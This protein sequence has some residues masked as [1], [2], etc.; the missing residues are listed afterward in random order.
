MTITY[1][2][3]KINYISKNNGQNAILFLH[4]WGGSTVSFI[5]LSNAID[6]KITKHILVDFPPF[7]ESEEPN[8]PWTV[9]DYS[10]MI[11]QILDQEKV[12]K[13]A[14]V[15][16]SF[17]GRV[18]IY[19]ANLYT[20]IV[21]K[22]LITGG[23]GIKPKNTLKKFFRKIKY[24]II[25][26]FKKNAQVG[27]SDYVKLSGVMKKTFSNIVGFDQTEMSKSVLCP[28]LL[29]YGQKDKETPL[30]MAKKLNRNI[31]NSELIVL[32]NCGHFAY[33]E[34]FSK[35]VN[36]TKIFIKE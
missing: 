11:K 28:V 32:K 19:L 25:K 31:K 27:S 1:K 24:K 23:A 22:M 12:K 29:V 36:I 8:C 30:Y 16:H 26:L 18:A 9:E 14:I 21:E 5:G 15:A 17:G 6:D 7:G 2:Q 20:Y 4:G 34:Q 35:F 13:V 33:L 3:T 10:I